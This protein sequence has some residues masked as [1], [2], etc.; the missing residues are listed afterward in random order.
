LVVGVL[1][2]GS[3]AL[4]YQGLNAPALAAADALLLEAADQ[5][6]AAADQPAGKD[7]HGDPLPP[8]AL[9]RLG[10][11]HFRHAGPITFVAFP[12]DGKT[13]LTASRD[14]TIRLW[15]LTSGKEIRRFDKPQGQAAAPVQ[16]VPRNQV[17]VRGGMNLSSLAM[18]PDGKTLAVPIGAAIQLFEI[19]TG[20]ELREIKTPLPASLLAFAP[21]G[22][23][24]AGRAADRT[25]FLW[26][27]NSGKEIRQIKSKQAAQPRAGF[28]VVGGFYGS[29]ASLVF[30]PDGKVLAMDDMQIDNQKINVAVRLVEVDTG[31]DIRQIKIEQNGLSGIAYSPDGKVL[32]YGSGN[33]IHL[34]QADNGNEIRKI[35]GLDSGIAALAFAPGGK[36]LAAKGARDPIVR[37]CEVDTGKIVRQLGNQPAPVGQNVVFGWGGGSTA[38]DLAYSPDGKLVGVGG[39]NVLS[40]FEVASGKELTQ[41]G[42]HRGPVSAVVISADGKTIVS[43]GADHTIRRWDATSGNELNQFAVPAGTTCL[44]FSPDGRSV[45]LGNATAIVI[46][47]VATGKEHLQ[48]KGHTNGTAAIGFSPDG[49]T[50]AS[51]GGDNT[52]RLHDVAK[53]TELRQ[54]NAQ[55]EVPNP[56]P[57]GA[58]VRMGFG[59]SLGLVFSPDGKMVASAGP[60]GNAGAQII[61]NNGGRAMGPGNTINLWSVSTGKVVRTITLPQQRSAVSMAFS[62]DGRVLATENADRTIT[63]WEVASGKERGHLGTPPGA[64]GQPGVVRAGVMLVGGIGSSGTTAS[65]H[66]LAFSPDARTLVARSADHTVRVWDVAAAKEL[67]QFKGHQGSVAA[68]AYAPNGKSVASGSDD[69]TILIWDV[70]RLSPTPKPAAV[71]LT[72]KDVE[73][74]WSDLAGDDGVKAFQSI[75]KLTS[76]PKQAVTFLQGQL[77]AA[78]PLDPQK[79]S[80][81]IKDLDS[82]GFA[83]RDEA[84]R[85]LEKLGELA[86]PPLEKVLASQPSLETRRRAEQLLEKVSG[87]VLS[88]EQVRLVRAVEVLEQSGTSEARQLLETLAKGAPGALPTRE[89]QAALSRFA[90][91]ATPEK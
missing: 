41:S 89:A 44:S 36:T 13:V 2:M 3:G 68:V 18:S 40:L 14:G 70:S 8:G 37:L 48:L 80:Q 75:Q 39:G 53:G 63:L 73:G 71:E 47:E 5:P 85:E 90:K 78:V 50:L 12:P 6:A 81:L 32:A 38:H 66:T 51:R 28:V 26:E 58:L 42:G 77:K 20:K 76:D 33:A 22:K 69:T 54:I 79:I 45:A 62:P 55:A 65:A 83:A 57:G 61:I 17:M 86:I 1:G 59:G 30:S 10:T 25:L 31:N 74:F 15:D 4:L 88:A 7:A 43:V 64:A 16:P 56:N 35:E 24:L 60:G 72:A 49:K 19:D 11:L 27:A 23:T 52:I 46:R 67:H 84:T 87:K 34:C 9:M 21:D 91:S 29:S 82:E